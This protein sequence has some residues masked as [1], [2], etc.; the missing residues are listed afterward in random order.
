MQCCESWDLKGQTSSSVRFYFESFSAG[1]RVCAALALSGSCA[2]ETH[3]E[4]GFV[5][6]LKQAAS[7]GSGQDT[8]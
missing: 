4:S 1:G 6:N 5:V 3:L 7:F 8:S 2:V